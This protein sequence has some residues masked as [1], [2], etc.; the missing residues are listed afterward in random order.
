MLIRGG[1]K[2]MTPLFDEVSLTDSKMSGSVPFKFY[3]NTS[4]IIA[5]VKFEVLWAQYMG[6]C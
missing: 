2:A 5:H 3:I 6:L 1:H 4:T